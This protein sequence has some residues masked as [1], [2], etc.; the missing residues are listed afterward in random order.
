MEAP[1]GNTI[2]EK[3]DRQMR[4]EPSPFKMTTRRRSSK[5]KLIDDSSAD[6]GDAEMIQDDHLSPPQA[7]CSVEE[8]GNDE[9]DNEDE[10]EKYYTPKQ[11][12]RV[13]DFEA[14][15]ADCSEQKKQDR[16]RQLDKVRSSLLSKI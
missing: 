4:G 16:E 13:L 2:A 14:A 1:L 7:V 12:S 10:E 6:E 3:A 8:Q 15:I 5:R 9:E 11:V